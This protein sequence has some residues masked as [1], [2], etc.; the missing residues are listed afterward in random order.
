MNS[1]RE[2]ALNIDRGV[3]TPCP[4]KQWIAVPAG[5]QLACR[6]TVRFAGVIQSI[7]IGLTVEPVLKSLSTTVGPQTPHDFS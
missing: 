5:V 7:H 1:A 4:P 3:W 6:F 2:P